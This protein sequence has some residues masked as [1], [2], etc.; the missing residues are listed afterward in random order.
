MNTPQLFDSLLSSHESAPTLIKP[1]ALGIVAARTK[2]IKARQA[3]TLIVATEKQPQTPTVADIARQLPLWAESVR[4]MP[5]EFVRCALFNAKNRNMPRT[6]LKNEKIAILGGGS[7]TYTGQELRQDDETVFLYLM[8]LA[9]TK[10][11]DNEYIEFTPY[12]FLKAIGWKISKEGYERL[13]DSLTRMQATA[14]AIHS[15]R[16]KMGV[17]LSMIPKFEW[18]DDED[19]TLKYYK[20]QLPKELITLFAGNHYSKIEWEQRQKLP[21]GIATWLHSYY[22]SHANPFPL[23]ISYLMSGAGIETKGREAKRL[24]KNA[25]VSLKEVEFLADYEIGGELV[26][27]S[28]I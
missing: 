5:N 19:K 1:D 3:K 9:R 21:V 7:I 2:A 4:C 24:M 17:S 6:Y 23:K 15:P 20:V 16:L 26:T 13:R 11:V 8:H 28:R 18:Q 12:S 27:V 10:P 25:L 22:T 14:L